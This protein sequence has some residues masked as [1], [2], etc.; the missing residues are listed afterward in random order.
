MS[1]TTP[2]SLDLFADKFESGLLDQISLLGQ[3]K[4]YKANQ[5]LI[6]FGMH[7]Q[8]IPL[9]LSGS[10]KVIREDQNGRELFLYFLGGGD[11]CAMSLTCCMNHKRSEIKAIVEED[12]EVIMIPL[13]YMDEWMKYPSWRQYVF[14][15]YNERFEEMLQAVDSLAFM[16]LDERLMNYLL[17][18]KQ[19]SGDFSIIKTHQE[20]AN[21]LN[22]SRVVISRLL[23]K[24]EQEDKIELHRNKIEI[25]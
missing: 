15:S 1:K 8:N 5:V 25:L 11:T 23:K 6:D 2:K 10:I 12:A 17:D 16:K 4:R 13:P 19:S 21:D 14:A 7:V 9:L 3:I 24:L 20:I 22:T 18:C